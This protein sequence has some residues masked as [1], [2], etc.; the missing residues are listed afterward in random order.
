MIKE[1]IIKRVLIA[2]EESQTVCKEF[3]KLGHKAFSCDILECSGNHP[4]WHIKGDVLNFLGKNKYNDFKGWDLMIAHPPCTYLSKVGNRWMN[5]PGRK[6]QR[7]AGVEF[8]MKLARANI[9]RKAIENPVGYMS[10]IFRKPNQIIQ[11]YYFGDNEQ[12][13][14]C[15]WLF[16]IPELTFPEENKLSKPKPSYVGKNGRKWYFN[17]RIGGSRKDSA[18]IKSKTFPGIAKAMANQWGNL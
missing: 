1:R 13:A 5:L 6:E 3:R 18:R 15:L 8:F 10:S 17:E 11:P 9:P 14:T 7:D 12:K 4:E 16:N 2:C